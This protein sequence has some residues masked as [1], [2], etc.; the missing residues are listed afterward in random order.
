VTPLKADDGWLVQP[1]SRRGFVGGAAACAAASLLPAQVAGPGTPAAR[2]PNLIFILADDLGYGDLGCYGQKQIL[3]PCLDRLAAEG[4]RFTQHYAGSTVCAPSRAALMLGRHTGHLRTPGQ[5]Q[6]LQPGETLAEPLCIPVGVEPDP[7]MSRNWRDDFHVVRRGSARASGDMTV[8]KLLQQAGYATACVGKWGL[9][10]A[11]TT[12]VPWQ[13][14]F[15]LFFGYLN[16]THAHNYYPD[17]LW[18]NGEK[19]PLRNLVTHTQGRDGKPGI[20]GAAT[21]R[22]EYSP[23]LFTAEALRFVE[24]NRDRPFFLYLT[25]TIPH[26]NN[27]AGLLKRHGME[28][29]DQGP[30]ADRPWP[31]PQRCH[32]AM[33][34]RLDRDI[35][36][37][38]ERLQALGLTEC[39]LVLFSSD[40]GPHREA[41]GDPDFF[42]SNGPLRGIKR[43]LYEGGIRVP[44]LASWPGRIPAGRTTEHVS[45]FWDFLPT[46]CDLAS[47][48]CP[49]GSDGISYL[50]TLLGRPDQR[51]HEYLYWELVEAGGKQ[52][53]RLGDWKA[54]RCD[55]FRDPPGAIELYN[56]SQDL[57]EAHDVAAE[58]PAVVAQAA[59]QFAGIAR[60]H[61]RPRA[62]DDRIA[63]GG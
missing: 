42:D 18:R 38:V 23:D 24:A 7:P 40:N 5:D 60:Q 22:L 50:P 41:G 37:L 44:L 61:P 4:L 17:F 34:S 48:E 57:A 16:Q 54:V 49:P 32:A 25:Y 15:D 20:G 47:L 52:A 59:A 51:Q 35:G 33:I 63:P 8:A 46:V 12:G 30:Y 43:D 36:T 55:L 9:G 1:V 28:V 62:F 26:A 53:L 21:E 45:A 58:H 56:L 27:E 39:T 14:G 2:P 19:V 6:V 13:Q 29:P 11:A 3:T 31:E 10:D